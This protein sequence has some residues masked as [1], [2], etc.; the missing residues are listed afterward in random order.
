MA[1]PERG[2][3]PQGRLPPHV[4]VKRIM[5]LLLI[6]RHG[7]SSWKDP[8]LDDHERPLNKR[9]RRDAPR[10][11]RLVQEEGLVPDLILSSTAVRARATAEAVAEASGYQGTLT[12]TRELYGAGPTAFL[13]ALSR[14]DDHYDRVMVVGHNPGL[15]Q[16]LRTLTHTEHAL[17]TAALAK[18]EIDIEAWSELHRLRR[19]KLV[20]LWRP[21]EL[22]PS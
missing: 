20:Q 12:L 5:K 13:E 4:L 8:S 6:L 16:L 21:K 1:A 2:D 22:G 19:G 7:K 17:P 9:G 11:G 10:M 15:E 3:A 14:L 18:V